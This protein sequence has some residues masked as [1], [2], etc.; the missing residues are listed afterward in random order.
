MNNFF[1]AKPYFTKC[2]IF[3]NSKPSHAVSHRLNLPFSPQGYF[4]TAA[5][6]T[7]RFYSLAHKTPSLLYQS[8]NLVTAAQIHSSRSVQN[9][10][11]APRK[12]FSSDSNKKQKPG[13]YWVP[14]KYGLASIAALQLYRIIK[15]QLSQDQEFSAEYEGRIIEGPWQ[16]KML[17]ALPLKALSRLFGS[18][19]ELEIPKMLRKPLLS[20]YIFA[21]GCNTEEMV[22]PNLADYPNLSTF[23]YRE[24]KLENRP[25]SNSDM[26]SPADGKVLHFGRVE[27]NNI[28]QVKGITYKIDSFLGKEHSDNGKSEQSSK[29]TEPFTEINSVEYSVENLLGA[30]T[31]NNENT[32]PLKHPSHINNYSTQ[33]QYNQLYYAVIYLAPGDYHR[34]HSPA[35]M[36]VKVRRHFNGELYSVSPY[37]A[38][39]LQNLFVLNER[40]CLLGEWKYGFMAYVPVGATNVGSINLNFEKE[41]KTNIPHK[42]RTE[43]QLSLSTA[44]LIEHRNGYEE[45]DY[46]KMPLYS[47]G[48]SLKKGEEMGGFKLGSTIVLVFEAPS[49]F[50]FD[51]V[52]GQKIKMGESIGNC[53]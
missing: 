22:N 14:V 51:I 8:V 35:D 50:K 11:F 47:K 26:I 49:S 6:S 30:E 15:K 16:V 52:S 5:T 43:M 2:K 31:P 23:F 40:V 10:Y 19:N 29:Q 7:T 32:K 13:W 25:I 42:I 41:L 34:F 17:T 1:R 3:I 12:G 21:F 45:L 9:V 39:R 53:A 4:R 18:F 38:K 46:T 27:G 33:P 20:L 44:D 36:A 37:L 24:I 28:E 48:V